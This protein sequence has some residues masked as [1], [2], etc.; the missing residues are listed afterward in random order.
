[1]GNLGPFLLSALLLV[2]ALLIAIPVHEMGHAAAAYFQGD[3]SVRYFG[4]FTL[5]PRRFLDPIGSLAVFVAL[6]GWGRRVPV[7]PNRISTTR[8]RLVHEL[9]GP[10]ASLLAAIVFGFVL[11]GLA[12][13]GIHQ[14]LTLSA[15]LISYLVY[16]IVF[17]NLSMFAF[18]LLPI[19]GLDGW[20]VLET[21]FRSRSPRFF[22]NA[23][24]RRRDILAGV[25]AAWFIGQ[26]IGIPVL[27]IV[28]TP[29]Y[30]PASLISVGRCIGYGVPR[31]N[32]LDPCLP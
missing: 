22:Y 8:Q 7:Q 23:S 14:S 17:L 31:F 11:R 15:G 5:N 26:F 3:R 10:A 29:F 2:P 18:Q 6:V 30:E 27:S 25:F 21:I 24:L 13:A 9:G 16:A 19:P 1:M 32:A 20:D 12:A 28:M 4:Y